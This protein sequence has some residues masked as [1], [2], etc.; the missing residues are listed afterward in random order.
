VDAWPM[1]FND[2]RLVNGQDI[3][4]YNLAFGLSTSGPAIFVP[5]V[6][7]FERTR[8]DLNGNGIINGQDILRFNFFFGK[9]CA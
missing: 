3:L 8:F 9:S 2:N 1:D 7:T 4:A 6:G 5:G